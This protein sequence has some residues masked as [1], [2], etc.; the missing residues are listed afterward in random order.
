MQESG[1]HTIS[2]K[3]DRS[4]LNPASLST[5]HIALLHV[6]TNTLTGDEGEG[7]RDDLLAESNYQS[8]NSEYLQN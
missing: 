6:N 3:E 5:E 7:G 2:Y 8:S 1:N 4:T